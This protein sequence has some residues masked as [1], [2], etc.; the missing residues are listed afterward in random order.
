MYKMTRQLNRDIYD[1]LNARKLIGP[2]VGRRAVQ[3]LM[4]SEGWNRGLSD[5]FPIRE[6][7]TCARV[8]ELC[9]PMLDKLCPQP[10]EKGWGPFCYQ[11]ICRIMFPARLRTAL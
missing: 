5:L 6:R 10:P 3:E 1:A 2:V 4:K 11:Y 8:L 7:I 9:S